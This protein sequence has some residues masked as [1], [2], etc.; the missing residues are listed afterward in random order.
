MYTDGKGAAHLIIAGGGFRDRFPDEP[1]RYWLSMDGANIFD[2]TRSRVPA[3][4]E[5]MLL[6]A[7][8]S[9][10]Q[11][12]YFI[13]H[14][15]NEYLIKFIA[16]RSKIDM[17]KIP[18]SIGGY[19]NTAAGSIPL[20]LAV[21]GSPRQDKMTFNVMFLGYGVGLSWGAVSMGVPRDC[22]L[23]QFVYGAQAETNPPN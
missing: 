16:A 22:L 1:S 6:F 15:A 5:E 4:I 12:D 3:L 18:L 2:F 17:K 21:A 19:G 7:G 9:A 10:N 11:Y 20:T 14:Q 23:H 13:F 8:K